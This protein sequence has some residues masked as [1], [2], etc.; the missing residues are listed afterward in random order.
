MA[1][2]AL[3]TLP[4]QETLL[5]LLRYD[6]ESGK[7]FWLRRTPDLFNEDPRFGRDG[8]CNMWNGKFAGKEAFTIPHSDGYLVGALFE[9]KGLRAHRVI[10][11]I[12]TGEEPEEVGH[13]NRDRSDNRFANLFA[14]R[15][16]DGARRSDRR[17]A[18]ARRN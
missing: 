6:R 1:S 16:G 5:R 10:W 18:H 13:H 15:S 8:R 4:D 11:K 2:H 12:M 17:R 3:R 14:Q 9:Q 7:L